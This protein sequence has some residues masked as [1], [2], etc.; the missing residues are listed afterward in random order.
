MS[1]P[2]L[3]MKEFCTITRR[4]I[5]KLPEPFHGYLENVVVDVELRPSA[6]TL[7]QLGYQPDAENRLMGLFQGLP[8]TEQHYGERHPN[9]ISLYKR[10][11]EAACRS[12]E[13]IQYEIRRTLMH[14]LAHHFGFSEEDLDEFESEPSPFDTVEPTEES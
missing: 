13:E 8:V 7:R 4:V 6:R 9:R 2:R 5:R 11:I 12:R 1:L 14:E 3:T 10:A